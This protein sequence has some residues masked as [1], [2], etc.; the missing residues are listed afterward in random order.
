ML[1]VKAPAKIN[2]TLEVLKK[3]PDGFH[4]IRSVL[5]TI[6]L[7]DELRIEAGEGI[8]FQCD[9][10]GWSA[11]K[12]LVSKTVALLKEAA[13]CAEG[14]AIKITKRIPLMSG[15]GGDSSDA[16]ALLRGL[17]E[18]WGLKLPTEK[19]AELAVKLGSDVVFF[20][21]GGTALATGRGETIAPLPSISRMWLALIV[22]DVPV[23]IGKTGRMY[24]NLK[25]SHFTSGDITQKLVEDLNKGKQF[26]P[27]MLFN[28]FENIAFS[29]FNIRRIYVD[30][31]I[32]LGA[33]HV[34]LAGSGPALFTM[35]PEKSRAEDIYIKCK[36]QGMKAYLA[37]TL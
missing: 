24:L 28:T 5:Q 19:L 23:E 3:R 37:A 22:P 29:D 11:G 4:E 34:H 2:L 12:S 10:A 6:D 1:T 32:K 8:S 16:A 14:A 7:C 20:L 27:A 15:V 25:P 17:N 33:F 26:K 18:F 30:H 13:G 21:H 36:N 31:L 9:M 35:F